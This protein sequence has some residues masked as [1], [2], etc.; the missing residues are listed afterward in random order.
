MSHSKLIPFWYLVPATVKIPTEKLATNQATAKGKGSHCVCI[1]AT[2]TP[3]FA[4]T[5]NATKG[6]DSFN[7]KES[8]LFHFEEKDD[9]MKLK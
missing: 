4:G 9:A 1:L 8:H 7:R 2:D 5:Q 3:R 6:K